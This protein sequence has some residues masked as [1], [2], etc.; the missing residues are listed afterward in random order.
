MRLVL[1]YFA[2]A[3]IDKFREATLDPDTG[4]YLFT[5]EDFNPEALHL[6]LNIALARNRQVP[7]EIDLEA[8]THL[9]I[10]TD[11]YD[12]EDALIT[13]SKD[14]IDMLTSTPNQD[15]LNPDIRRQILWV[16]A[17]WSLQ[18]TVRDERLRCGPYK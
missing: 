11:Y 8:R 1:S 12:M 6:L 2:K 5:T 17:L 10:I 15:Y 3:F 9:C 7:W 13:W 18:V 14:W 16:F 4:K